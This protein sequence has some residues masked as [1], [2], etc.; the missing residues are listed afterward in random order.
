MAIPKSVKY[1][2]CDCEGLS[3]VCVQQKA[4]EQRS[5]LGEA[6]DMFSLHSSTA[7]SVTIAEISA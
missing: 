7:V 2:G 4:S 6:S 5:I 1:F 3:F